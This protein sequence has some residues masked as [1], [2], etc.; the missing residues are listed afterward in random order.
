MSEE[1]KNALDTISAKVTDSVKESEAKILNKVNESLKES[2]ETTEQKL[3]EIEKREQVVLRNEPPFFRTRG[4]VF[5][6]YP[7]L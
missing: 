2:Q 6:W 1:I 4:T 7:T 5:C 3:N